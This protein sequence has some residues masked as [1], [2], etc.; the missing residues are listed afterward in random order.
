ME[1]RLLIGYDFG[2]RYTQISCFN[3]ETLEP[4]TIGM[5]EGTDSFLIPTVLGV[6]K[7]SHEWLFGTEAIKK[8]SK[9][10]IGRAHV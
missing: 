10:E 9:D 5:G 3:R 6:T 2:K 4:D 1:N 8:A 7:E